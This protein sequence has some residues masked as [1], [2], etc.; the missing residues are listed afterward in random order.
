MYYCLAV[1]NDCAYEKAIETRN[2][3]H[4]CHAFQQ[5]LWSERNL[6]KDCADLYCISIKPF[7]VE[8]IDMFDI[9]AVYKDD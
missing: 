2:G 9:R 4:A 1:Y 7:E 5:W 8:Y 6:T 3:E